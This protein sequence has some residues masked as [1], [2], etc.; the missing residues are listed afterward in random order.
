MNQT[1]DEHRIQ[2]DAARPQEPPRPADGDLPSRLTPFPGSGSPGRATG[3]PGEP[4]EF[5]GLT[6][7]PVNP[8]Q[9]TELP[10]KKTLVVEA[11]A[12]AALG[13]VVGGILGAA[14]GGW[15]EALLGVLIGAALGVLD[16]MFVGAWT[17]PTGRLTAG[18][19]LGA[20]PRILGVTL[21]ALAA[22]WSFTAAV[23]RS[24]FDEP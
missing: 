4:G 17:G 18:T 20:M 3:R 11:V 5:A 12:G 21:L 9:A 6:A 22:P 19:V 14:V 10:P 2:A 13:C 16:G 24:D 8:F 1:G 7:F 23:S 15:W